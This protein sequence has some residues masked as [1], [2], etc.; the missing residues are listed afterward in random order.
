MRLKRT[1]VS[2]VGY[3][4]AQEK[5]GQADA[6]AAAIYAGAYG[7]DPEFYQFMKSMETLQTSLDQKTWLIL[8]T[9]SD[10]L[11]YFKDAGGR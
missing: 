9:D 2:S 6:R 5:K 7:R 1:S 8:S 3:R 11:R 4:S 10:L